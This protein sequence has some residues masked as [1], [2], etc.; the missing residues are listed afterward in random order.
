MAT[1]NWYP[2]PAGPGR[3]RWWDGQAWTNHTSPTSA[4]SPTSTWTTYGTP[5]AAGPT[6]YAPASYA[7]T[8]YAQTWEPQPSSRRPLFIV[9]GVVGGI[10]VAVLLAVNVLHVH[11][12]VTT[13][14]T[15]DN[16]V[17]EF[18]YTMQ[19][20][21]SLAQVNAAA[22][23]LHPAC[24]K[25]GQKQ[26]CFDASQQMAVVISSMRQTLMA[27]HVPPR[28]AAANA[29]L[30]A[31]LNLDLQAFG[32]RCLAIMNNDNNLWQQSNEAIASAEQSVN[33][34]LREYPANTVVASS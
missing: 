23:A 34:A 20:R 7:P 22:Q 18:G 33:A 13:V 1:P 17:E 8:T 26:A 30:L 3:L 24:D 19:V 32:Q 11:G 14:T 2:D 21:S 4:T 29:D 12:A 25:G 16:S 10:V 28:Y 9:L 6:S 15:G 31:A 27:N 5:A